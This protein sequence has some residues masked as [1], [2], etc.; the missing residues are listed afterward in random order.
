MKVLLLILSIM[1]F[2]LYFYREPPMTIRKNDEDHIY[3]PACGTIMD[4]IYQSDNT[5]LIP[6]FLSVFDI[7]QQTFPVSGLITDV[8]YDATGKFNIAYKV[9]KSND[10][11]K[12]IHTLKNKNGI[13]KI[14]QIAG[15]LARR[16]N[17]FND[18]NTKI[19]NG[20]KLG[21]IHFGSRVDIIIPNADRVELKVVKGQKVRG[22]NTLLGQY[23]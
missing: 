5:I 20:Q 14:Y 12:I 19:E 15:L 13:F 2:L 4:I 17:Y 22:S 11:E 7:H 16:I 9:N 23:K 18:I 6:I 10:N 8:K 21:L 3:S 1:I